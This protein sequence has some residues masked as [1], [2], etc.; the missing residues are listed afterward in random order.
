[1]NPSLFSADGLV[2]LI[3]LLTIGITIAGGLIACNATR[4]VR[5]VAGLMICFIGVGALYYFLN[6]PF[7]AMMQVLIYI[8]AVAVTISFAIMLAAPEDAKD[9]GPIGALSGPLGFMTGL[10]LA[11]GLTMIAFKTAWTSAAKINN[12]SVEIIGIQLL[13]EYSM[14]FELISIVLLIAI[15]GALVIA[16]EGRKS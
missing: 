3:F 8:G 4:L 5:A 6:S 11:V 7:V 12:G 13:T 9:H 1:M 16:R 2:G 14:V 15:I 10:L